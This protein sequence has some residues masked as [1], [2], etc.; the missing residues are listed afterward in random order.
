MDTAA[1]AAYSSGSA[2]YRFLCRP[3]NMHA[4]LEP[5]P[6]RDHAFPHRVGRDPLP[7][8]SEA[9]WGRQP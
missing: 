6:V 8:R 9:R 1:L 3:W 2:P 4:D 7:A 5:G